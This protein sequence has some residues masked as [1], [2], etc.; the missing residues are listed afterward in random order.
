MFLD[1]LHDLLLAPHLFVT[2]PAT[3]AAVCLDHLHVLPVLVLVLLHVLKP[4]GLEAVPGAGHDHVGWLAELADDALQSVGRVDPLF[5]QHL[6]A[7][8]SLHLPTFQHVAGCLLQ[9]GPGQPATAR[10]GA[11]ETI[12]LVSRGQMLL[13]P[14]TG[15]VDFSTEQ[16]LLL[17]HLLHRVLQAPPLPLDNL[18]TGPEVSHLLIRAVLS[19]P[20]PA[21][22]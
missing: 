13:H 19:L 14:L 4:G 7:A 1:V 2:Q 8:L 5:L 10:L 21:D 17:L 16:T 15:P 11:G 6:L 20:P 3:V 18:Q 22:G 12:L 9:L